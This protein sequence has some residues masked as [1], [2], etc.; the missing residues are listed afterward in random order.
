VSYQIF[1]WGESRNYQL[2]LE[3]EDTVTEPIMIEFNDTVQ[4]L[5]S[6]NDFNFIVTLEGNCY[7]WG[8]NL[9]GRLGFANSIK[10]QRFPVQVK[11]LSKIKSVAMGK[12]HCIAITTNYEA[13]SWGHG[14]HGQLGLD[15]ITSEVCNRIRRPRP[16]KY[17]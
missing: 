15:Q 6:R 5:F 11:S 17:C 7:S 1:A 8:S 12:H 14:M 13:Y 2:A 9:F 3:T 10:N 4:H 16:P